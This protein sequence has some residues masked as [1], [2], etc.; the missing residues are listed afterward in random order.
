MCHLSSDLS[1]FLSCSGSLQCR[2]GAVPERG[3]DQHHHEDFHHRQCDQCSRKSHWCI[4]TSCRGGRGGIPFADL[5]GIFGS[6]DHAALLSGSG[7]CPLPVAADSGVEKRAAEDH[8]GNRGAKRSG[9]RHFPAGQGRPQ[10]HC[11]FV[12]HQPDRCQWH[13]PEYLE[14]GVSG[15][16]GNGCR[17]YHGYRS[18]YGSR[19]YPAGGSLF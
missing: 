4:C 1:L 9:E 12:R 11:G 3:K 5:P 13:C 18:V 14:R 2:C 19:R 7:R 16:R 6:G 10:Q 8:H 17:F 15:Q